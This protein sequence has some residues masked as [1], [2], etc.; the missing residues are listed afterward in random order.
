MSDLEAL[1]DMARMPEELAEAWKLIH[2][3]S[4]GDY[5][6]RAEDWLARN[7]DYAPEH[8]HPTRQAE[9]LRALPC[10]MP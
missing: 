3:M 8:L 7:R 5:W 4:A 6:Q 2:V 9:S 10:D 1:Q